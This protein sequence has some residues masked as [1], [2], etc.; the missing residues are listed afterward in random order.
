MKLKI[1]L[2]KNVQ[3]NLSSNLTYLSKKIIESEAKYILENARFCKAK[4]S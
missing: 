3:I 1:L 2:L 4:W